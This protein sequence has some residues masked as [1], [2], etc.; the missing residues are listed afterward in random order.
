MAY[1]KKITAFFC[2]LLLL[3]TPLKSQVD[4]DIQD[5]IEIYLENTETEADFT[6]M[7]D[8]ISGFLEKPV[9]LNS[10]T[11]DE[12]TR[13]PLISHA[14]AVKIV[15]HRNRFGP[16]LNIMELQVAGFTA[17]HIRAIQP[18]VTT[19]LSPA[20]TWTLWK[21]DI[22]N[23]KTEIISTTRHRNFVNIPDDALGDNFSQSLRLRY[24]LPGKYSFGITAD[25]D[26]GELWWNKGPD[27]ISMHVMVSGLGKIKNAVVG[28]YLLSIGQGLVL[29]SGLGM[30]RSAMVMNIKRGQQQLRPYRGINEFMFHRGAAAEFSLKKYT[31]LVAVSQNKQD[32]RLTGDTTL[33]DFTFSSI[34]LDGYHRNK[35]E[36]SAK[37]NTART[38]VGA[39]LGHTDRRGNA[40]LG[41]ATFHYNNPL[42]SNSDLYKLFYPNG[43]LQSFFNVYQGHTIGRIHIFSEAAYSPNNRS[44]AIST[45]ILTSLGK[46]ADFSLHYRNYSPGF[47]SPFSTAFGNSSQNEK[48][49]YSGIK[50]NFNRKFSFS[51]YTDFWRQPWLTFRLNE[52]S[53]NTATLWQIDYSPVKRGNFYLRAWTQN[54]SI[55]NSGSE[56][57]KTI[58][59]LQ[60]KSLRL[61]AAWPVGNNIVLQMR[62]ER[63]LA[64]LE[65]GEKYNSALAFVQ[66]S[67]KLT[68]STQFHLRYTLFDVPYYY[69]RTFVYENQLLYDFSTVAY[70]G[71]GSGWFAMVN[72]RINKQFKI[73]LRYWQQWVS[74]GASEDVTNKKGI[75]FQLIYSRS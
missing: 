34:D 42:S 61:H 46:F 55:N 24:R 62:G 49:F 63:S 72:H 58:T 71:N 47:I 16:Y 14:D 21:K 44:K 10:A 3:A 33:T 73:G 11:V 50:I 20:Q 9:S 66:L 17:E 32:S 22:R 18:F 30:G 60:I 31:V 28:D 37:G 68:K 39:W 48:G 25:K 57:V 8:E 67:G 4:K 13:F 36:L 70:Y 5:L 64:T 7:L 56:P 38:M 69:N 40:G 43:N 19:Q 23:G 1:F 53:R 52:P 54:R 59:N 2:A 29:G 35:N 6:Q 15:S 74:T 26:A 27:F 75:F 41:F 51:T 65:S 45:G 12:L